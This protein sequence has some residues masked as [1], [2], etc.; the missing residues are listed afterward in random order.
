LPDIIVYGREEYEK[1]RR[2]IKDLPE[3]D[4]AIEF[5]ASRGLPTDYFIVEDLMGKIVFGNTIKNYNN[6]HGYLPKTLSDYL[7]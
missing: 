6:L 3:Y 2:E 5:C 1:L 4:E 7:G